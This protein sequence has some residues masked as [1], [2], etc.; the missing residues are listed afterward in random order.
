MFCS[1]LYGD[2]DGREAVP[3][4]EGRVGVLDDAALAVAF[5]EAQR[6][7]GHLAVLHVQHLQVKAVGRHDLQALARDA[8]AR[9]EAQVSEYMAAITIHSDFGASKIKC[10]RASTSPL[11]FSV[12]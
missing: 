5:H 12:K 1:G 7:H 8:L 10:V 4:E 2:S 9:L 11:L 6:L 3:S